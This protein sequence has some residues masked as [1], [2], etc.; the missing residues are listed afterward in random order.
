MGQ[1][2]FDL[3]S[4]ASLARQRLFCSVWTCALEIYRRP[5]ASRIAG[6]FRFTI[7][8]KSRFVDGYSTHVQGVRGTNKY[9]RVYSE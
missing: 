5:W 3:I 2:R 8:L 6:D 7:D 4:C 1:C 9:Y